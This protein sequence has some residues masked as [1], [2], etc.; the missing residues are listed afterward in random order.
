MIIGIDIDDTLVSSSES[1]EQLIKKYNIDF[2]KK[3]KD[4]WTQE[5]KNFIYGNY[6]E[7]I[8]MNA[9]IKD[10]AKEVLDYL[11]S[12][13][14]K[15]IIIT[16]RSNNYCKNIEAFTKEFVKKENL[17]IS[18]I[19]FGQ[20]KKSDIAKELKLDLMIDDSVYVYN[21]MKEDNIDC[22]LFGDKIKD[23][24]EVLEYIERKASSNE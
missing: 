4:K 21:N 19:Y 14:C 17:R 22:I 11:D 5:E 24:K 9:K 16:A 3:F 12:L 20:G 13:G 10:N 2:K 1:F 7:E 8:L 6:L 15:L 23:W 18:E